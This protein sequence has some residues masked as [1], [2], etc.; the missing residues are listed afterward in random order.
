[1]SELNEAVQLLWDTMLVNQIDRVSANFVLTSRNGLACETQ[2]NDLPFLGQRIDDT[3]IGDLFVCDVETLMEVILSGWLG[4]YSAV[5]LV[6]WE[7]DDS[8]LRTVCRTKVAATFD[9]TTFRIEVKAM[10]PE[11]TWTRVEANLDI[12][13]SP[14]RHLAHGSGS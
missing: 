14:L 4:D 3:E 11:V 12:E 2:R 1:M 13:P 7:P 5:E 10:V 9:A 6:V 8:S